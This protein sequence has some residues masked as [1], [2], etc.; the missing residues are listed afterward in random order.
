MSKAQPI[1]HIDEDSYRLNATVTPGLVHE[2]N[3]LLTGIYFNLET[4]RELFDE[5]HPASESLE[6]INQGV[7]RIK[8]LL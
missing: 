7:E 8:D 3:N 2:M 5:N 4:I 1:S 6:E